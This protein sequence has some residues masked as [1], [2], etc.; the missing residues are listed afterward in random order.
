ML[1]QAHLLNTNARERDRAMIAG[2]YAMQSHSRDH[3]QSTRTVNRARREK[4]GEN[5]T[6]LTFIADHKGNSPPA[7][8]NRDFASAVTAICAFGCRLRAG[9]AQ[10]LR[11]GALTAGLLVLRARPGTV[12]DQGC[13]MRVAL[14][15]DRG[16]D[17]AVRPALA[18]R[19]VGRDP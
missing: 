18:A 16:T 3:P 14:A 2:S 1:F 17:D 15:R 7:F 4:L 13:G 10:R 9:S 11:S 6:A 5:C 19:P 8:A 12:L